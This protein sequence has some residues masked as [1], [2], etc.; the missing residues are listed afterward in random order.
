MSKKLLKI[1]EII[2][3]ERKRQKLRIDFV[4]KEINI[5]KEYVKMIENGTLD[6]KLSKILTS[7]YLGIY[8]SLLNIKSNEYLKDYLEKDK[9]ENYS[10]N[11]YIISKISKNN[12]SIL[13]ILAF[14]IFII[15]TNLYLE[16]N[17]LY[18]KEQMTQKIKILY[19]N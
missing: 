16:K 17:V 8:M 12:I 13:T 7:R 5:S 14:I 19:Q 9:K 18:Q 10:F 4:A 3:K 15:I 1:G 6:N 11:K 2:F